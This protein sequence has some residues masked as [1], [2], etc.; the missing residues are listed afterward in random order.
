M[1]PLPSGLI[2]VSNP[3]RSAN[4]SIKGN[5]VSWINEYDKL[6]NEI[7][8]RHYSPKTLRSYKG[9]AQKFQTFTKSKSPDLLSTN[10]VKEF[11]THLAVNRNVASSTQN[12]AFNSL[13]FFFRYVLN[14]EFGKVDG[15]VRAKRKSY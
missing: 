8:V 11:L 15:V 7:K 9:W 6:K 1:R 13:L 2:R 12:Q 14:R 5:G 3:Q 10:D 4:M